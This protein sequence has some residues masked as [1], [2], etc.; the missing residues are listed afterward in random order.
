MILQ[1]IIRYP[2][3]PTKIQVM[4]GNQMVFVKS[5]SGVANLGECETYFDQKTDTVKPVHG[6]NRLLAIFLIF[7]SN[8]L[9]LNL[10]NISFPKTIE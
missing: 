2:I 9:N 10:R 8:S 7:G 6:K 3:R 5:K 4:P 1:L